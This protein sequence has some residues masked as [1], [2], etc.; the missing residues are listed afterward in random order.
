MASMIDNCGMINETEGSLRAQMKKRMPER[1]E[2]IEEMRFG[3]FTK[4]FFCSHA[5]GLT[6]WVLDG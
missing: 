4:R 6:V 5:G 3:A 1:A 2:E